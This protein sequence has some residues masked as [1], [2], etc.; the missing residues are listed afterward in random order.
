ML[1]GAN[2]MPWGR[3]LLA[4]AT[5]GILWPKLDSAFYQRVDIKHESRKFG[6]TWH[7]AVGA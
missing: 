2:H 7:H 4:N 6:T 1:A 3:F 5:G